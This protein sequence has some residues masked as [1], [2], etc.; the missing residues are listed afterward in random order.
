MKT[1]KEIL[2]WWENLGKDKR[3]DDI[4]S[5]LKNIAIPFLSDKKGVIT[6]I[7]IMPSNCKYPVYLSFWKDECIRI[8]GF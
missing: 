4:S 2:E 7:K 5:F 3:N 8:T 6:E 1:K